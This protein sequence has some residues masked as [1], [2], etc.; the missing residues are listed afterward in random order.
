MKYETP[1]GI[2]GTEKISVRFGTYGF[3]RKKITDLFVPGSA[4]NY[5]SYANNHYLP[6][7]VDEN[8]ICDRWCTWNS[9]VQYKSLVSGGEALSA[10]AA[11][12][13]FSYIPILMMYV[14][15]PQYATPLD[16]DYV[17]KAPYVYP[18]A[19]PGGTYPTYKISNYVSSSAPGVYDGQLCAKIKDM[20]SDWVTGWTLPVGIG[21]GPKHRAH[22]CHLAMNPSDPGPAN[23]PEGITEW[24]CYAPE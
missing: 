13:N 12:Q 11:E 20:F 2:A 21:E 24:P 15:K 22:H 16:C 18:I 5:V 19:D 23:C 8:Y 6:Y 9:D 10:L 1:C 7:T 4:F 14:A 17:C 3:N